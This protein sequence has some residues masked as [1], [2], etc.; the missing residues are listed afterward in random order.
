MAQLNCGR[1]DTL[2]SLIEG[3]KSLYF[4]PPL[5]HTLSKITA[6]VKPFSSLTKI[7]NGLSVDVTSQDFKPLMTALDENLTSGEKSDTYCLVFGGDGEPLSITHKY[8]M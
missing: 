2:P 4:W 8:P 1:C 3:A 5:G 7:A 6:T